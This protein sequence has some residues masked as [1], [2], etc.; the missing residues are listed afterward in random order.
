M[1]NPKMNSC[2]ELV[3]QCA[4]H[5][6]IYGQAQFYNG[7]N[8]DS[9]IQRCK[10]KYLF[11]ISKIQHDHKDLLSKNELKCLDYKTRHFDR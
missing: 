7:P 6:F 9:R 8:Y 5:V 4:I 1:Y 10:I 2:I 3:H 11:L